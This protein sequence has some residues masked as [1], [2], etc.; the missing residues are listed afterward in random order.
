MAEEGFKRKLTAILSADVAGYSR[1]MAEDETATVKTL[2]IY[3][4]IMFTLIKQ[5]R[6]RVIDSPGDNLLAE[7]SSVV[8]AVQCAVAMQKEFQARNAELPENR[9]MEFRIGVN[10]GDVIEEG[11]RIYGDGVN[12]AARLEALA[13]PGGI[14][15]SKTAFDHIESKLPLGYEYLGEQEVKNIPK[16]VGAYRV[17]MEPRVTVAEEIEKKK[18][19][20]VWQRKSILAGG[21]ALVLV[22][23]ALAVWNFYFRPSIEPASVERMAFPLPD[24]PS[25]AVLPFANMSGDPQQEYFSDGLTGDIITNLSM[26]PRLFVIARTSTFT[27]KGNVVKV[28]QVAEELG[29]RYVLEGSV[30]KSGERIR[31]SA[32]L[33]DA[34]TGRLLWAE[35]YDRELEDYFALQ[36]EI[37]M[38]IMSAIQVKLTRGESARLGKKETDN[39]EAYIKVLQASEYFSRR[40]K[41]GN[42]QARKLAE[43]AIALDPEYPRPYALL[44]AISHV[45]VFLGLSK[46]PRKSLQQ[47]VELHQKALA[48][49]ESHPHAN[50][51]LAMVYAMQRQ[52]EKS[53]A[54]AERAVALNPNMP[55]PNV[56]LGGALFRLGRYEE[57]IQYGEK[58]IRLDPKGLDFYFIHLGIAYCFAGR[59]EEAIAAVKKAIERAPNSALW[60]LDLAAIY[61]MAGR[62][63]EARAAAAEVLRLDPKFSLEHYGKANNW[64][65]AEKEPWFEALRKAGMPEKP[66]LPLP[67]KPSIA[68]LPFVNM[69]GDPKQEYFSD[70]LTEN[71]ITGLSKTPKL[72]VIARNST[73][74]YKGKPTKVQ[75]VGRELGVRYVLE[76]S[77]QKSVDRVRI[78]AQLVDAKS[79]NHIWA[80]RY[81]RDLRDIFAVQDDIT[82]KVITELR[83]KLTAGEQARLRA[84]GT[85]NLQ[86]YLKYLKAREYFHRF[87]PEDNTR[88]LKILKEV[89]AMDPRYPS[90]YVTLAYTHLMDAS[91]RPSESPKQSFGNAMKLAQKALAMDQND[92]E[93]HRL[94]GFIYMVARQHDKAIAEGE[95]TLKLDPNSADGHVRLG[96]ILNVA[97]KPEEAITSMKRGIRLNPF[98]PN[99]YLHS[100]A[101]AY[102]NAGRYE[103]AI[104]AG[105]KAIEIE[106]KDLHARLHIAASYSLLDRLEEASAAAKEILQINSKFSL[107]HYAKILPYKNQE[108]TERFIA[109]LRKAGLK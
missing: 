87:N 24:E 90:P 51:A 101:S 77:V 21:V 40:N 67:D 64:R 73:S 61:S 76:G 103:E 98:P 84:K 66:P 107:V 75:K 37:I 50:S 59:Y 46:S 49:D 28:Q 38:K 53:L 62:E 100:L 48:I 17:L 52:H 44:G 105:K 22:V 69:S 8:D 106:P 92:P 91:Y 33:I 102:R 85:E 95:K 32:Q 108:D 12:I 26:V 94:L 29:V 13:D 81:D 63:E 14:C 74:T 78:T 80:E 70:G 16:P 99:W 96:Q 23:I 79:G 6:G 71:V 7:F 15:V 20:P 36:D 47:A 18:A 72:F 88:A 5:H 39:L 55:H 25:I 93:A 86:A 104:R 2:E 43:E 35:R 9:R 65:K 58:A 82:M 3:R 11:E 34:L 10:L 30:Q 45:D 89:I 31:I 4:E 97:G 109:A 83:V 41:E 27:Y 42:I 54:Q 56:M 1:L 57:A 60:H 68:V 19:V